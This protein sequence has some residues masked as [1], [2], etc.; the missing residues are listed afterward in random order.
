MVNVV[1]TLDFRMCLNA[2]GFEAAH[3]TGHL[4]GGVERGEVLH[5]RG[6]TH[7]FVLGEDDDAVLV[8]HRHNGAVEIAVFPGMAGALLA[9]DGIGVDVVAGEAVFRGDQ[10]GR[11]AL[12]HEIAGEVDGRVHVPGTAGHAHA[13][14]RHAFDAA[15][16]DD[17]IGALR[18]LA[19]REIDGIETGGAESRDLHARRLVGVTG[20]EGGSFWNDG[21]GFEHRIDATHDDVVDGRGVEPVAVAQRFQHL[22]GEARRRHFVQSAILLAAPARRAHVVVNEDFGHRVIS[23]GQ[24]SLLEFV[25]ICRLGVRRVNPPRQRGGLPQ[26]Q[27]AAASSAISVSAPVSMRALRS[28][29]S[30]RMRSMKNFAVTSLFFRYSARAV[31][32]AASFSSAALAIF[33]HI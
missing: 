10:V 1:D 4:E 29:V 16:N 2:D 28:A 23:L 3:L 19:G 26:T 14:A 8:L 12:R 22:C 18:D 24:L 17:V 6:R 30:G 11:N 25:F 31:S 21:A 9:L 7:V 15:G 20:F 27:N 32:P 13:D 33:A 5:R